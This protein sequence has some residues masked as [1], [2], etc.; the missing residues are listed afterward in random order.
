MKKI[1]LI[2]LIIIALVFL[3]VGIF[4]NNMFFLRLTTILF[5]IVSAILL[6]I[7]KK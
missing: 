6:I 3:V 2:F 1:F 4:T 5:A 7:N